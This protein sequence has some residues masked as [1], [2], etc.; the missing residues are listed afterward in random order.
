MVRSIRACIPP[1][2]ATR[3]FTLGSQIVARS[4]SAVRAISNLDSVRGEVLKSLDRLLIRTE[5]VAS[6]RIEGLAATSEEYARAQNGNKSNASAVAMV[7][8]T[9]ALSGLIA[10]VGITG[11]ITEMAIKTAHHTLMK[12]L[13]REQESAGQYRR[14]QNWIGGSNHSPLGAIFIPHHQKLLRS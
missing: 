9:H 3:T 8:G 5:S 2:I 11:K 7:A 14:V 6:S 12:D 10:C 4:E 1:E 13:P